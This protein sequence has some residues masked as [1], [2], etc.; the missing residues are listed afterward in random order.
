MAD[1]TARDRQTCR[2]GSSLRAGKSR[3]R[4]GIVCRIIIITSGGQM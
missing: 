4:F 1:D 3:S 2:V